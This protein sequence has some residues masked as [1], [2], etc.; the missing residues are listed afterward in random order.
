MELADVLVVWIEMSVYISRKDALKTGGFM[1][2]TQ[3]LEP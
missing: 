2:I 1:S 3:H